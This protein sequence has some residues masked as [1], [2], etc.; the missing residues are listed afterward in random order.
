MMLRRRLVGTTYLGLAL[1]LV[2]AGCSGN[3][4]KS[5]T[6]SAAGAAPATAGDSSQAGAAGE[7]SAGGQPTAAADG[8]PALMRAH[9]PVPPGHGGDAVPGPG[10]VGGPSPHGELRWDAPG[11]WTAERPASQMRMAQ[12]RVPAA[13]G[14]GEPGECV[15]FYFGPG[16][17]GDASSNVARWASQFS[18]PKGG[19]AES[20]VT[21]QKV[22][23]RLVTRIEVAGTYQPTSM[24]FGGD[25]PP[26][27]PGYML[28][29][30]IVPGG[31]AN[32]FFRCTGPEKT[33]QANRQAFDGL[34]ASIR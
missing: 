14:D 23:E 11:G 30:A 13:A 1:A 19:P 5:N 20:R 24:A 22:G 10:P 12:Y 9:D 25:Q 4:D 8:R 17:G 31:D 34:V 27:R 3:Q 15:V 29:G 18:A 6:T 32:W 16:Q 28:L 2:L 21:E 26:P 33:M 7:P